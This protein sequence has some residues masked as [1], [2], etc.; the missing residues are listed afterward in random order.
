VRVVGQLLER[1]DLH[2]RNADA[3]AKAYPFRIGESLRFL[4]D[5][6]VKNLKVRCS[7]CQGV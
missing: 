3:I 6:L 4:V 5:K 7:F 1:E 2:A